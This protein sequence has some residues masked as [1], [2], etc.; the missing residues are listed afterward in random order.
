MSKHGGLHV[1]P[2][3]YQFQMFLFVFCLSRLYALVALVYMPAQLNYNLQRIRVRIHVCPTTYVCNMYQIIVK[4]LCVTIYLVAVELGR[5]P[6]AGMVIL[7]A[8]RVE[9]FTILDTWYT[10]ESFVCCY[11]NAI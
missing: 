9:D 4:H 7:A 6:V 2:A 10:T 3:R 5:N 11:S 1:D 8:R